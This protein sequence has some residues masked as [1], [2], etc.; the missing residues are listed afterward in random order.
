MST[1]TLDELEEAL[2][3]VDLI[4]T[5]RQVAERIVSFA[6]ADRIPEP[7]PLIVEIEWW[8]A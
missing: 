7:A 4:G 6:Q 1:I 5:P 2:A 8:E 3:H